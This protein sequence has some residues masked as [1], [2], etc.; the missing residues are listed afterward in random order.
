MKATFEALRNTY[1]FFTPDLWAPTTFEL[2]PY[3]KHS[4]FLADNKKKEVAV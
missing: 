1:T 4:D 2:N 3:Q